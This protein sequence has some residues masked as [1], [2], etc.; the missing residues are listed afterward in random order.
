MGEHFR[1]NDISV[2]FSENWVHIR[3]HILGIAENDKEHALLK[4]LQKPRLQ[5]CEDPLLEKLEARG[6]SCFFVWCSHLPAA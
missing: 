2:N 4:L 5:D 6:V 3:F 1:C